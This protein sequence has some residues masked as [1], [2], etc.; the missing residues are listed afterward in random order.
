MYH[1]K[2]SSHER[3]SCL[4]DTN[5]ALVQS[6]FDPQPPSS[7]GAS[8][9]LL[10]MIMHN[11]PDA[12]CERILSHVRVAAAEGNPNAKLVIVDSILMYACREVAVGE[13]ENT[14]EIEGLSQKDAMAPEP[15]LANWGS[16]NALA[17]K[18][19]I[20]VCIFNVNSL[21]GERTILMV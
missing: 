21:I 17:Y 10:R 11:W 7:A 19:D 12:E 3:A 20:Q 6:F 1:S 14:G 13:G 16:A 8:V 18:L 5:L 4:V 9:F 2:V 15:L